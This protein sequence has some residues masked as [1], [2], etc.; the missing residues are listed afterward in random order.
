MQPSSNDRSV[1]QHGIKPIVDSVVESVEGIDEPMEDNHPTVP[2]W[3]ALGTYPIVLGVVILAA[4][5]F[6]FLLQ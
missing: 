5:A 6:W 1:D 4:L 3:L 2:A